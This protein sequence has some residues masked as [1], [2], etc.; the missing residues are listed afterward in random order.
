MADFRDLV[1]GGYSPVRPGFGS[2]AD[3]PGATQ[4]SRMDEREFR[5]KATKSTQDRASQAAFDLRVIFCVKIVIKFT[6]VPWLL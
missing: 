3:P 4:A 2:A 6:L 5:S 1:G